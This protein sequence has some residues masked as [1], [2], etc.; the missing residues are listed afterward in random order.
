[1]KK[2]KIA[3]IIIISVL[4]ISFFAF[5]ISLLDKELIFAIIYIFLYY[6]SVVVQ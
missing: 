5:V 3:V 6:V 1:M 4:V 2:K